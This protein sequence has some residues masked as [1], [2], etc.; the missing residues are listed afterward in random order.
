MEKGHEVMSAC[1]DTQYD[2]LACYSSR[3][4]ELEL[5]R[6]PG[7]DPDP[8][9]DGAGSGRLRRSNARRRDTRCC[10]NVCDRFS[11]CRFEAGAGNVMLFDES[12]TFHSNS[13]F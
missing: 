8:I 5:A 9:E 2:L 1:M 7:T 6:T 13:I 3:P 4:S 11:L 10:C 12:E